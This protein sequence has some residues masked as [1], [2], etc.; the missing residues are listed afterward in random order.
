MHGAF[1]LDTQFWG[2]A[3]PRPSLDRT[4]RPCPAAHR[5]RKQ[6]RHRGPRWQGV[7]RATPRSSDLNHHLPERATVEMGESCF[8]LAK[9]I[10]TI[11]HRLDAVALDCV[12]HFFEAVSM[13]HR[14]AL[15]YGSS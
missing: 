13:P 6:T 8:G 10:D 4:E 9:G 3:Q 11:D 7:H 5:E 14:D 15:D 12:V 1:H 2:G